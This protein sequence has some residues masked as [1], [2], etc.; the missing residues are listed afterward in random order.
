MLDLPRLAMQGPYDLH[1]RFSYSGS[2]ENFN[3]NTAGFVIVGVF[4]LTWAVALSIWHSAR[5]SRNG[6]LAA[7]RTGSGD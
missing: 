1:R 6:D 4:V 3:I 5:S 7:A 2:L